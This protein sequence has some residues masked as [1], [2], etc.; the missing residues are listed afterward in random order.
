MVALLVAV[1]VLVVISGAETIHIFRIRRM[2]ALVFGPER[3][4]TL[5]AVIAPPLR[6]AAV[7]ALAWGLVTLSGESTDA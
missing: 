5:L 3:R 7:T 2:S 6:V 4:A 1:T